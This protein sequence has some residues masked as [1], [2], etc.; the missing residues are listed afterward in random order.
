MFSRTVILTDLS[1]TSISET[2]IDENGSKD[3]LI[4]PKHLSWM[5]VG[6]VEKGEPMP[7]TTTGFEAN[8]AWR[9][10]RE[11]H[12]AIGKFLI[13]YSMQ[14]KEEYRC[15]YPLYNFFVMPTP[16]RV[17]YSVIPKPIISGFLQSDTNHIV[18]GVSAE[19]IERLINSSARQM[20]QYELQ[21]ISLR[22]IY[23]SGETA[24]CLIGLISLLEWLL[25]A[26]YF[27]TAKRQMS[28]R[29]LLKENDLSEIRKKH[30]KVLWKAIDIRNGAVHGSPPTRDALFVPNEKK[31]NLLSL[32]N[33][34]DFESHQFFDELFSSCFDVFRMV[35]IDIG[36]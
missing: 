23:R 17:T 21:L 30:E 35:N 3:E 24:L 6:H 25:N 16:G 31:R 2:F 26:S 28:F 12:F 34:S 9:I 10:H 7:L 11:C 15:P 22:G 32:G 20:S 33:L 1:L 14:T 18:D 13:E 19:R 36:G 8:I 4:V 27:P 5:T 29:L